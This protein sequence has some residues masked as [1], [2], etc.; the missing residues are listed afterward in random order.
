M[1]IAV[2]LKVGPQLQ[3]VGPATQN[4]TLAAMH[5]G[6]A[7]FRVKATDTLGS[8]NLSF[9]ARAGGKA[10]QQAVDVS[11]RPAAAFRTQLDVSRI[12]ADKKEKLPNLRKMYDAYA[13]R[14]ASMSTGPLVLSQGLASYLVNYQHYCSEQLVSASVPRL[15]AAKW[16][17]TPS[18]RNAL[19]SQPVDDK[20]ANAAAIGQFLDVLR[21]RQNGQGGFGVWTATPDADPFVSAY[22]MHVLIDARERG[23]AVP[24][25]M[26]DAGTQYLQQLA[27]NERLGTL[28]Q[29]RQRAYAVYL[30]TRQGNVTTNSLAAVQKRLQDAFPN[31]W[32]SDLA[33]GWLAASYQ[34]LKQDKEAARLIAGPQEVL[35]RKP[36]R[37]E[38]YS[39]GYYFDPLTRDAS[40]LY[41]LAKHFPD[42]AQALPPRVLD[43][44]AG[45]I[46]HNRF[47]TLSS[48]MTILALDAYAS[49]NAAGLDKLAIEEVRADDSAKDI[50]S[51]QGSVMRSG[52]WSAAASQLRFVNG[53][54]LPAWQITS[55]TGYDRTAPTQAIKNGLEIIREYTDASGKPLDKVTLGQEIDVHLKIRAT[56]NKTLGNVAIVDLLPG[57]FDP[58]T[59]PPPV[60]D[61]ADGDAQAGQDAAANAAPAP[62]RSPV[63]LPGSTW[64]PQYADVRED[65]VV[66]YG[67]ASGDVREFVY[68]IKATNAG[69]FIVP[70]AYGESMYDRRVQAQSAGG[71]ALDVVR[72]P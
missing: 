47:N 21:A 42:R 19:Q 66:I 60:T 58:V 61:A 68:R 64:Q 39:Y 37:D 35:E 25:E 62:W 28:D 4:L 72:A 55:Q 17:S 26:L 46:Q 18:L 43:N 6:V 36:S 45:P 29:L 15:F 70:P 16:M 3:V 30:L 23:I 63:G 49:Q 11:I 57:G 10:A 1:P 48:A 12:D 22:A 65:R 14:E 44:L 51:A 53:S 54:S 20:G 69:R 7:L 2:A 71:A 38:P 8:G 52:T 24:K 27:A 67:S 59:T 34:L 56:D 5:E 40:V 9:S 13:A 32:K 31:D 41:L 33:A 50:S